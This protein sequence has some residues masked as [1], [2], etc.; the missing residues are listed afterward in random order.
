MVDKLLPIIL[1]LGAALLVA[2]IMT[3]LGIIFILTGEW[4]AITIGLLIVVT[5]PTVGSFLSRQC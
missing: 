1:P 2:T 5:I 4:G 3:T